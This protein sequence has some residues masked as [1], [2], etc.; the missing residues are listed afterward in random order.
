MDSSEQPSIK[1]DEQSIDQQ[2]FETLLAQLDA[3]IPNDELMLLRIA[4]EK[5]KQEVRYSQYRQRIIQMAQTD[6]H[7][8]LQSIRAKI[9]TYA[10]RGERQ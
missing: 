3:L 10:S 8:A 7:A 2:I 9:A 1:K 5:E 4:G 6:I